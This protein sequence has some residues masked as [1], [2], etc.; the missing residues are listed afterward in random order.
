MTERNENF[1][2]SVRNTKVN[3]IFNKLYWQMNYLSTIL[4]SKV[5]ENQVNALY[6]NSNPISDIGIP[7][8]MCANALHPR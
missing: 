2:D 8:T 6:K 1:R 5:S 3:L 7:K 4:V